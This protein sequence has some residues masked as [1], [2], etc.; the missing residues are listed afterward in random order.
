MTSYFKGIQALSHMDDIKESYGSD[1]C[2]CV[3]IV[4]LRG[5]PFFFN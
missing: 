4:L 2:V 5:F 3:C 1:V